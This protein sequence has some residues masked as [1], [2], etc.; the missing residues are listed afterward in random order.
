MAPVVE[1]QLSDAE[2]FRN[3]NVVKVVVDRDG[4]AMYF[5]RAPIPFTRAGCP[6]APAYGRCGVFPGSS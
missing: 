2:E 3:P 5:S 4:Y 1:K 6:P